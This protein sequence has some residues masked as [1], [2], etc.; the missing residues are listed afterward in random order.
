MHKRKPTTGKWVPF[1]RKTTKE[2]VVVNRMRL[3]HTKL[4]HGYMFESEAEGQRPLCS[5]CG[6]AVMTVKHIL[7]I[8]PSLRDKRKELI[9]KT[10]VRRDIQDWL[11]ET[12]DL[13]EVI[14]FVKELDIMKCI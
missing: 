10:N 8:Y 1:K 2:E 9:G 5:W 6:E 12:A 3:E 11:G 7:V 4:T 13:R 14:H